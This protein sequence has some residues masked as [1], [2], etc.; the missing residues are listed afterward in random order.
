MKLVKTCHQHFTGN[1]LW[2]NVSGGTNGEPQAKAAVVHSIPA[3]VAFTSGTISH[4]AT[5]SKL[6]REGSQDLHF[7]TI[8][9]DVLGEIITFLYWSWH[10]TRRRPQSDALGADYKFAPQTPLLFEIMAAAVYFDLPVLVDICAASAAANFDCITSF[11]G[12][13][14]PLVRNILSRLNIGD[15]CVSEYDLISPEKD[16]NAPVLAIDV[17]A[18][19]ADRAIV[20]T[21]PIWGRNYLKLQSMCTIARGICVRFYVEQCMIRE[22]NDAAEQKLARIILREELH[23]SEIRLMVRRTTSRRTL[24]MWMETIERMQ[25][26]QQLEVVVEGISDS[27][28][29]D[30]AH[31]SRGGKYK[32]KVT[33]NV[34]TPVPHEHLVALSDKVAED[35]SSS[36]KKVLPLPKLQ[37]GWD[38]VSM[39]HGGAVATPGAA[40]ARSL[41]PLE[42]AEKLQ[43]PDIA[44]QYLITPNGISWQTLAVI[45]EH[46]MLTELDIGGHVIGIDGV[47]ILGSALAAQKC[48]L[49]RLKLARCQLTSLGVKVLSTSLRS[50]T[51]IKLLDLTGNI[52]SEDPQACDAARAFANDLQAGSATSLEE[53]GLSGNHLT[54]LGQ[55]AIFEAFARRPRI[56]ALD[57][58]DMDLNSSLTHL[59]GAVATR[60]GRRSLR[61]QRLNLSG[62]RIRPRTFREF[63][64][65]LLGHA[66]AA[67]LKDGGG[68]DGA[69]PRITEL[70]L[71]DVPF[72]NVFAESLA[73]LLRQGG[74]SVTKLI[75]ARSRDETGSDAALG[76]QGCSILLAGLHGN[77]ALRHV[78]LSGQFLTDE[79][80]EA[81]AG[82]IQTTQVEE[83]ML[84][85]NCIEDSGAMKLQT[86]LAKSRG[87]RVLTDL[88]GNRL[89]VSGVRQVQDVMHQADGQGGVV[90]F[91]CQREKP[92]AGDTRAEI[93]H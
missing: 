81:I 27:L 43:A 85:S 49:V 6:F 33:F 21:S 54:T 39:P 67:A 89:S 83:L 68:G 1:D 58:A 34:A 47:T 71:S 10:K 40:N 88:G 42:N 52:S 7:P 53:L 38:P 32:L 62:T 17:A 20:D 86:A 73:H 77:Q 69:P 41:K 2:V 92:G 8:S 51:S 19:L 36:T 35:S 56:V 74:L 16:T 48:I 82:F 78:N 46:L 26:L 91:A 15:L 45:S 76:N 4:I 50:N 93:M 57:L 24:D 22:L 3:A 65:V 84:A 5:C 37:Q 61:M 31:F 59:G 80:C 90:I 23:L 75:L 9:E 87:R 28:Q 12:L 70:N 29:E 30:F 72:C 63:C 44:V 79:A 66:T 14:R 64:S 60:R 55:I 11:G 18:D 25:Q 13:L